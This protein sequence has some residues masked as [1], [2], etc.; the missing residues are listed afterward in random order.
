VW[1]ASHRFIPDDWLFYWSMTL[2]GTTSNEIKRESIYPMQ[3]E[4][5]VGRYSPANH[6]YQFK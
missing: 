4:Q 3:L 2:R 6:P 1:F 5:R